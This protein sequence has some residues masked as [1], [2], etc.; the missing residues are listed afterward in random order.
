MRRKEKCIGVK[1]IILHIT[2]YLLLCT[3]YNEMA[4][5]LYHQKHMIDVK[6]KKKY[7]LVSVS[8]ASPFC[9]Y[10]PKS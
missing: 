5:K 3:Q 2:D 1:I 4:E 10:E 6:K 9:L 7:P 8:P